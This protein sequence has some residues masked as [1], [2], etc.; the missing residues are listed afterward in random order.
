MA[1][2]FA[3][4]LFCR[5]DSELL[6]GC[7]ALSFLYALISVPTLRGAVGFE[8]FAVRSSTFIVYSG[9]VLGKQ[10]LASVRNY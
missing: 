7:Y 10:S 5:T 6:T 1:A 4:F 3:I 9:L 8:I 2:V